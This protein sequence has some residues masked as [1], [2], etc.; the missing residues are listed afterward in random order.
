MPLNQNE[1]HE[2]HQKLIK[3]RQDL[4]DTLQQNF[5]A[6]HED[7]PLNFPD[8]NDQASAEVDRNFELR[9]HDRERKLIRKIDQAIERIK[10]HNFGFC[11]GCGGDIGFKRLVARLVT[12]LCIECKTT[13]EQ[14]ERTHI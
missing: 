10:D 4:D 1:L 9:I 11:D 2:F 14:E 7:N 8:P 3:W 6:M 5:H 13:Q 12:T